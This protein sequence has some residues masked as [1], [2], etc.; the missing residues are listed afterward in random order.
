MFSFMKRSKAE[1]EAWKEGY[2]E[3]FE[4]QWNALESLYHEHTQALEKQVALRDRLIAMQKEL[5]GRQKEV[6]NMQREL[7][8]LLKKQNKKLTETSN[9][10]N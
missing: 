3:E 6:I 10:S 5:I 7:I 4:K 8:E 2:A 1:D 9:V